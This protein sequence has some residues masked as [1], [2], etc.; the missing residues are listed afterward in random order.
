M[1]PLVANLISAFHE[2]NTRVYRVVQGVVWALIVL[3]IALLIFETVLPKDGPVGHF[4]IQLDRAILIVFSIEI[5]LRVATFQP[6]A[7][8]VFHHAPFGQLRAHVLARL[9]FEFRPMM[10][11]D[12]LAA[13]QLEHMTQHPY[14][15]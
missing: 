13:N 9:V 1:K 2:P 12:I 10:L 15:E 14:I 7:L 4:L 6:P 5:L 8:K 11:I 3:S